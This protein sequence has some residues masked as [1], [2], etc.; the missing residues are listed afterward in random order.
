MQIGARPGAKFSAFGGALS[1]RI[2]QTV[3]GR[4]IVQSWRA[5]PFHKGDHDSTLIL[6]FLP[7]G[8]TRGRIDLVHVNVPAHDYLSGS[9][10]GHQTVALTSG[11]E[12]VSA[13]SSASDANSYGGARPDHAPFA[14]VDGD[15]TT[16][17]QSDPGPGP[18]G[19]RWEL[20]FVGPTSLSGV[21][22][23][24]AVAAGGA[25]PASVRV[26]G[27]GAFIVRP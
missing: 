21:H 16:S 25:Q 15:E 5:K 14:A 7:A 13:G 10:L 22:L 26:S 17:W 8:R 23:R 4:L 9:D 24:F 18:R 3:P 20:D 6:R 19:A 2:L 1:G 11:A 12:A 27:K